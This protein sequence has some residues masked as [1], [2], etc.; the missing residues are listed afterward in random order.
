MAQEIY[1][2]VGLDASI[3]MQKEFPDFGFIAKEIDKN[4]A[5][6]FS[7]RPSDNVEDFRAFMECMRGWSDYIE[8]SEN[9][10]YEIDKLIT[11]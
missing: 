1:Y 10:A 8:I 7:H 6:I 4:E 9:D 3:E 5:D 11:I 2:L